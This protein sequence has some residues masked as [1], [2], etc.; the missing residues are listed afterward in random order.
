NLFPQRESILGVPRDRIG[1]LITQPEARKL[2][3]GLDPYRLY[4][5]VSGVNAVRLRRLMS[6]LEGEDYPADPSL[7]YAQ[8]RSA[9]IGA[10]LSL[11]DLDLGRDI[12]GYEKVKRRLD[13]EI[14]QVMARKDAIDDKA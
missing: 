6:S 12:G 2:G 13:Q 7:A 10:E 1:H 8:L 3:R 14:L 11:P 4:K 5:Y 9:T